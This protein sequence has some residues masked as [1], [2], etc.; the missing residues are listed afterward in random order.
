MLSPNSSD[1]NQIGNLSSAKLK[2]QDQSQKIALICAVSWQTTWHQ[3]NQAYLSHN[4][5]EF[6]QIWNLSSPKLK[7]SDQAKKFHLSMQF[8]R[9]LPSIS[10]IKHILAITHQNS[11]KFEI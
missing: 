1:F 2:Y 5:S 10:K 11:T 7:Y 9:K 6:N 4:S 8:P 3:Q